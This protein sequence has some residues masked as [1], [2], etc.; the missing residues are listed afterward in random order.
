MNKKFFKILISSAGRRVELINCF[1]LS[2]EKMPYVECKII[3]VDKNPELSAACQLSDK[4]FQ[5]VDCEHPKYIQ[6]LLNLCLKNNIKIII[7][8]IDNELILLAKA[9]NEFKKRVFI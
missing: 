7:P 9:R 4:Y 6:D 8:T 3:T 2:L 1:K 5:I